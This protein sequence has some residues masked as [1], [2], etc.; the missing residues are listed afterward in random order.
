MIPLRLASCNLHLQSNRIAH[1][2][3]DDLQT[4]K[5]KTIQSLVSHTEMDHI[6]SPPIQ[7]HVRRKIV[8]NSRF[9]GRFLSCRRTLRSVFLLC[10]RDGFLE[11][12]MR[13]FQ[14]HSRSMLEARE[15][16]G[17]QS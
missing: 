16:T 1:S 6:Q 14:V 11:W 2:K 4:E 3:Y 9:T 8:S 5:F 15:R 10:S 12:E 13:L 7:E 17:E